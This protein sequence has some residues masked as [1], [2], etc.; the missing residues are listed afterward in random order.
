[1]RSNHRLKKS[2]LLLCIMWMIKQI[3]A[4]GADQS[5]LVQGKKYWILL[6]KIFKLLQKYKKL[7]NCFRYTT[8]HQ[9]NTNYF[10]FLDAGLKAPLL[11]QSP[12]NLHKHQWWI[13]HLPNIIHS[14][15]KL[16]LDQCRRQITIQLELTALVSRPSFKTNRK[17]TRKNE[18]SFF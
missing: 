1:M 7:S 6:S 10:N 17:K 2:P 14:T 13:I 3:V 9:T 15:G 8:K 18:T 12:L 4:P 5:V 16:I 11:E